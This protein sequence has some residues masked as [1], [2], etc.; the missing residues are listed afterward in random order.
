[1]QWVPGQCPRQ[2]PAL[3]VWD[4]PRK[5]GGWASLDCML[6]QATQAGL[7]TAAARKPD[8]CGSIAVRP[9]FCRFLSNKP[10]E[11]SIGCSCI[12][13]S[14]NGYSLDSAPA[15][16]AQFIVIPASP[17]TGIELS[18]FALYGDGNSALCGSSSADQ[19]AMCKLG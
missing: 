19:G 10:D 18:C 14:I 17:D 7:Q 3:A 2:M 5:Q 6:Q 15:P 4:F 11:R 12:Q 16:A 8:S 13:C 1:M 9:R